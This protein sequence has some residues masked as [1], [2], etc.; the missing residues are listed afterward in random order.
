L[1]AYN[2]ETALS[3]ALGRHYARAADEAYALIPEALV[4]F[5]DIIPGHGELLVRLDPLAGL[6]RTHAL[7]ALATSSP[8]PRALHGDL[9]SG[10][11]AICVYRKAL[12]G[13]VFDRRRRRHDRGVVSGRRPA[14][15]PKSRADLA[16]RGQPRECLVIVP[17]G[18][19]A[20]I[21]S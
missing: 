20:S 4:G 7:D 15:A 21:I 18:A 1:A 2:A 10:V 14:A 12:V 5:G 8:T 11:R 13:S 6:R 9:D 3:C 17:A 16:C 19:A